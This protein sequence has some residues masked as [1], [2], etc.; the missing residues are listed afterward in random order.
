[1]TPAH[2]EVVRNIKNVVVKTEKEYVQFFLDFK[3]Q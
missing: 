2:V 1:M 3:G